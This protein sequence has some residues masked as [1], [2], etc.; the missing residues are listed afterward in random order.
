MD[1]FESN[2]AQSNI[3]TASASEPPALA[4]GRR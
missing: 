1:T 4:D 3:G 2:V